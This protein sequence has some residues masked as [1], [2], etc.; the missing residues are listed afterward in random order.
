MPHFSVE[1]DRIPVAVGLDAL[2]TVRSGLAPDLVAAGSASGKLTYAPATAASAHGPVEQ[3]LAGSLIIDGF[4]LSGDGLSEPISIPKILLVPALMPA[5]QPS[6]ASQALTATVAIPAGGVTPLVVSTRLACSGY[7]LAVHGAASIPRGRELAHLTGIA[8]AAA[9]DALTGDPVSVDL[10]AEGPWMTGQTTPHRLAA[11]GPS[12]N[13]AATGTVAPPAV[14]TD[15]LTGTV[16]LR[17][18]SWKANYLVN[19]VEISQATLHLN[20]GELRWDPVVFSYGPVKGTASLSLPAACAASQLCPPTFQV[21][22]GSLDAAVLQ[23]ASL[24]AHKRGTLLSTLIDHLRRSAASAWPRLEGTIKAKSLALGPVTLHDPVASIYTTA[25][26]AEITAFDAGLLGG[27][28]HGTGS[29]HAAVTV[30]DKPTYELEGQLEKLNPSVVGQMLGW[31]SSGGSFDGNGKIALTGYTGNDLAA[32]AK[33]N[34]HFEWQ[35]GTV[36]ASP[37]SGP[38][39]PALTRFDHW[40]ADA[41]IANGTLTLKENQVKRGAHTAPVQ[42]VVTLAVRPRIAFAAPKQAQA[43]RP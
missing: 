8:D 22:F 29:F 34:L 10:V 41:S 27:R 33:G 4:Q 31:R 21:Q 32:S 25:N 24:G 11:G 20:A 42:A 35:H 16:T 12:T 37:A 15:S 40:A 39:P 5:S 1:L 38:V 19:R 9:L 28:V 6:G 17:N 43:K 13:I 3:P 18:A 23:T 26:G 30:K 14:S 2:R 36:A 7:Q